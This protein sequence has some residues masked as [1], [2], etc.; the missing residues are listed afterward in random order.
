ML[1]FL[2][3]LLLLLLVNITAV[4]DAFP[5]ISKTWSDSSMLF[6]QTISDESTSGEFL[7]SAPLL[8]SLPIA[9]IAVDGIVYSWHSFSRIGRNLINEYLS[10]LNTLS[11]K[12]LCIKSSIL[13][14]HEK[15]FLLAPLHWISPA[16]HYY[17]FT[18]RHIII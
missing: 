10:Q 15:L 3:I 13:C 8:P 11:A 2:H 7:L 14:G 1:R 9:E 6:S 17:V 12:L 16:C 5:P 4:K 18:L